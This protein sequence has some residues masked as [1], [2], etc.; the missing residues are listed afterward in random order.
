MVCVE[1]AEDLQRHGIDLLGT[2]RLDG[3]H[4]LNG[5]HGVPLDIGIPQRDAARTGNAGRVLGQVEDRDGP[6]EAGPRS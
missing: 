3:F 5:Q 4:L 6:E 2:H 1:G